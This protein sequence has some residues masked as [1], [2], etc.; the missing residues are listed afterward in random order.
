[1]ENMTRYA[2][3][4]V[5]I[6]ATLLLNACVKE[7]QPISPHSQG[8]TTVSQV[9][10]GATYA[11]Q[12][13]Y[14]LGNNSIVKTNARMDWDIAFDCAD[15]GHWMHLNTS[16][17]AQAAVTNTT[18]FDEVTAS[19]GLSFRPDPAN[20]QTDSLAIGD[21][22][23]HGKVCV[24]DRG[25]DPDGR[26]IGKMKLQITGLE[27]GTYSFRYANLD[28]TNE[29]TAQVTKNDLYNTIAFS[30]ATN[31]AANI[32]PPKDQYDLCFTQYTYVFYDPYTPYSVN[33]VLI[34]PY[35]TQVAVDTLETFDA[36]NL[37]DVAS[38][39][40]SP[41]LDKIGYDWKEY[42]FTTSSYTI[43]TTKTFIIK[44][45]SGLYYK[46]HFIDFYNDQGQKGSPKFEFQRL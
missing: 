39:S 14:S 7:E 6:A 45:K 13:W 30:F 17:A 29:H 1:M 4:T 34:N 23:Q 22:L 32:E 15:T 42:S 18:Q 37:A 3:A 20:G 26:A 11:T 31:Q 41:A 21:W 40:F 8:S 28:G 25:Y 10:E 35:N 16:L 27:N 38:Y 24:I 33:G 5:A 36:I 9:D 43:L 44:D 2:I 19:T 46:L 12:V